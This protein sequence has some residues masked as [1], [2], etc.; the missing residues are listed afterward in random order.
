[1]TDF[2]KWQYYY[3]RGWATKDQLKQVVSFGRITPEEYETMTGETYQT[4]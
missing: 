1:M 4:A 2:Q 3:K